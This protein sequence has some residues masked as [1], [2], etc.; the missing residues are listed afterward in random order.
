LFEENGG[1]S[2]GEIEEDVEESDQT[3]NGKIQFVIFHRRSPS[4]DVIKL[5]SMKS[6]A[7]RLVNT[8]IHFLCTY[9]RA[10]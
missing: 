2:D 8:T 1:E 3:K 9:K 7:P 6:A 4:V 10:Q 5:F